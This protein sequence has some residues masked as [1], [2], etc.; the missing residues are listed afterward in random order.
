M[1]MALYVRNC[2]TAFSVY[3][4][5]TSYGSLDREAETE[6]IASCVDMVRTGT[7]E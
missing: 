6:S 2:Q 5:A 1:A 3:Q 7:V 4:V